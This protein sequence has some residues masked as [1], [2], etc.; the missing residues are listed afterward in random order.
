MF[1][2]TDEHTDTGIVFIFYLGRLLRGVSYDI[3]FGCETR[4]TKK[5][6]RE[7]VKVDF[8][9]ERNLSAPH[10]KRGAVMILNC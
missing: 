2:R 9:E 3:Q 6:V 10:S 1:G 5:A 4:D 7:R 8:T